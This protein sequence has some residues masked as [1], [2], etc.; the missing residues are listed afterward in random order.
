M[1]RFKRSSL[2]ILLALSILVTF[3]CSYGGVTAAANDAPAPAISSGT[4]GLAQNIQDG[5]ILHA[6]NWSYNTIKNNM[7]DIAAAGYSAVPVSYTHL[8][9]SL[10]EILLQVQHVRHFNPSTSV[11]VARHLVAFA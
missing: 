11:D 1:S 6:W 5:V 3:V 10:C 7:A 4:Y 9:D 2:S 8:R